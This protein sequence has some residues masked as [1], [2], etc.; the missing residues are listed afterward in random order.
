MAITRAARCAAVSR[1]YREVDLGNI[2]EALAI[3][4]DD[5][6][7]E[8]SGLVLFGA[9]RIRHFFLHERN[10]AEARHRVDGIIVDGNQGAAWGELRG[11]T[12]DGSALETAW[13]DIFGFDGDRVRYRRSYF[14]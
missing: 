1:Y 4:H 6:V 2:D 10:I 14:S 13:C 12:L 5:A 9:Q 11:R 8:R 7:Y 3:F